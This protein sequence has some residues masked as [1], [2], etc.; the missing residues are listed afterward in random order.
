MS[1][2]KNN[3]KISEKHKTN[4]NLSYVFNL[5]TRVKFLTL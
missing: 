1:N 4:V 3:K 2:Y 5:M